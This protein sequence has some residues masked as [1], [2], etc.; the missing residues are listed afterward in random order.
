MKV[1]PELAGSAKE[2]LPLAQKAKE[3][4][5]AFSLV[6]TDAH[7]PELDGFRFVQ[8]IRTNEA[9]SD[10]SIIMMLTSA[11]QQGDRVRCRERGLT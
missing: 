3:D 4:G 1:Q 7:M 10:V 5:R 9:L 6:L 8:Q 11:D 2:A